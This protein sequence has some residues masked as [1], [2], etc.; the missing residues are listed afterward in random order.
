MI[1]CQNPNYI[2]PLEN[3]VNDVILFDSEEE[4]IENAL[5]NP[6]AKAFGFEV[7]ERGTGTCR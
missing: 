5:C 1:H 2:L 7:F 4:A 3:D 6:Y